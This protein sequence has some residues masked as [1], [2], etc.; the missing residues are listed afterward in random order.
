[1]GEEIMTDTGNIISTDSGLLIVPAF[2]KL[3]TQASGT[4]NA[5]VKAGMQSSSPAYMTARAALVAA[6]SKVGEYLGKTKQYG[7]PDA[8]W[9]RLKSV[10]ASA[11]WL[12]NPSTVFMGPLQAVHT[13]DT[14]TTRIRELYMEIASEIASI[15][16]GI[17][18]ESNRKYLS[19]SYDEAKTFT[20]K[21]AT[22]PQG[23]WDSFSA[24]REKARKLLIA[25]MTPIIGTVF[26]AL[27]EPPLEPAL[28]VAMRLT[29]AISDLNAWIKAGAKAG[30]AAYDAAIA[31]LQAAVATAKVYLDHTTATTNTATWSKIKELYN[32]AIWMLNPVKPVFMA[33]FQTVTPAVPVTP[34]TPYIATPT[35]SYEPSFW[36]KY[37]TWITVGVIGATGYAAW[38]IISSPKASSISISNPGDWDEARDHLDEAKKAKSEGDLRHMWL[39]AKEAG[40]HAS[41]LPTKDKKKIRAAIQK[42]LLAK[43]NRNR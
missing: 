22:L 33:P 20:V 3:L 8:D 23:E 37:K 10:Y 40:L 30:D 31:Q 21:P 5:F 34:D 14:A 38:R 24:M 25:T 7:V 16:R 19:K 11:L 12:L 35:F 6:V 36:E 43:R 1:M 28:V 2:T 17:Q 39:H 42:V 15:E 9:Q 27:K 18:V 13:V 26:T 29:K 41:L 32:T 4:L